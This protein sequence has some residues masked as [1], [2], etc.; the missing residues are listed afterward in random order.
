MS[1]QA[2][3][4]VSAVELVAAERR[5]Q[6][7]VKG[8]TPAHDV[9]QG[10]GPLVAAALCY[11]SV[12][13]SPSMITDLAVVVCVVM[14]PAVIVRA[15]ALVRRRYSR[16]TGTP[17]RP[18][19]VTSAFGAGTVAAGA[20]LWW[21]A[22]ALPLWWGPVVVTGLLVAVFV[23]VEWAVASAKA[24][25]SGPEQNEVGSE[26]RRAAHGSVAEHLVAV[27]QVSNVPVLHDPNAKP[28]RNIS[29]LAA[30]CGELGTGK[31]KS[32]R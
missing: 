7:D 13:V 1:A 17:D 16:V 5:R 21:S 26:P 23:A 18:L 20:G 19:L 11:L 24:R 31:P 6:I 30:V 27:D 2:P 29:G 28:V 12:V 15:F 14:F 3:P 8:W 4:A 25:D 10:S 32:P 9:E 22:M